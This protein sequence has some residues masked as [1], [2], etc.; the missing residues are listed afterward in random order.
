M[1]NCGG[2]AGGFAPPETA[3][4]YLRCPSLAMLDEI[5]LAFTLAPYSKMLLLQC[6]S[7]LNTNTGGVESK[8]SE[9]RSA[10]IQLCKER[11]V[12]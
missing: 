7:E 2:D 3:A 12:L 8:F 6:L 1:M 5:S 4:S 10:S 11:L 9:E